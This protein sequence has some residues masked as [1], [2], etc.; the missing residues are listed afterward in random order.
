M[1]DWVFFVAS[2]V[3]WTVARPE[4]L[5]ILCIL[6]AMFY[7]RVFGYVAVSVMLAIGAL[8]VADWMLHPLESRYPANPD[9]SDA[10]GI[11]I[12][13]GGSNSDLHAHWNSVS[14]NEHGERFHAALSLAHLYP[15]LPVVFTG[16]SGSLNRSLP[17][18]ASS[19]RAILLA[20]GME[21][22][23][24]VV[25]GE[26]RNTAENAQFTRAML[27][28]S[29]DDTWILITSAWHM[30]RSVATFCAAGWPS[31]IP[32]PVDHQSLPDRPFFNWAFAYRLYQVNIAAKE[33]IGLLAYRWTTGGQ[34]TD[35]AWPVGDTFGSQMNP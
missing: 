21:N 29:A 23:R 3:F 22:S 2:K 33:W 32:Y 18:E 14:I 28:D 35:P 30:P 26:S 4:S 5:I 31:I 9:V 11:L 34:A 20:T 10:V 17:G 8:P 1:L 6:L 15:H 19:A 25:E 24:L 16:G 27:G 13:G 12:L 7:R